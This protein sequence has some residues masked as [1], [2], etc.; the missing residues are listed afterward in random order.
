MP[1]NPLQDAASLAAHRA[2]GNTGLAAIYGAAVAAE[3]LDFAAQGAMAL[4]LAVSSG[5]L[6]LPPALGAAL[7]AAW[8]AA[9]ALPLVLAAADKVSLAC[10][11]VSCGSGLAGESLQLKQSCARERAHDERAAAA[12]AGTAAS[13]PVLGG[14]EGGRPPA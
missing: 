1:P 11:A 9:P 10:A 2:A 13:A 6:P 14:E 12:A 4:G 7:A 5:L 8:P 3:L